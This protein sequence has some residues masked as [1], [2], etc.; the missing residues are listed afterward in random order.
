MLGQQQL[1]KVHWVQIFTFGFH[2][3]W[4]LFWHRRVMDVGG[5]FKLNWG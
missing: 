5:S 1:M 4:M 2:F 3:T